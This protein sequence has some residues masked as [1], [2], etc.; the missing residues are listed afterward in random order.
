VK[1]LVILA[2]TPTLTLTLDLTLILYKLLPHPLSLTL[3]TAGVI[4]M[5]IVPK[6]VCTGGNFGLTNL[7]M[8]L[9]RAKEAGRLKPNLKTLYRH[10]DGGSDNC[11]HMTHVFHWLL[12][13]LGIFD[14]VV[15][16]RF[17]AGY[18]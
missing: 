17:D 14:K 5:A 8:A 6:Y 9:K 15:W 3:T 13:Y 7:L 16:F 12:V 18:I 11:N 1:F 10:T 2:L 4:R